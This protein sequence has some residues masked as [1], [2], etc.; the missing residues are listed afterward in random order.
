MPEPICDLCGAPNPTWRYPGQ[1]FI[2]SIGGTPAG[3]SEGDWHVCWQCHTLIDLGDRKALEIRCLDTYIMGH[4]E[5][6]MDTVWIM[7]AMRD[8]QRQFFENRTGKPVRIEV[9][10]ASA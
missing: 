10:R 2:A 8:I 3:I 1:D 7:D 9:E 6:V 4:P 5:S